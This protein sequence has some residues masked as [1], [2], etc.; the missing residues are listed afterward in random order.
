MAAHGTAVAGVAPLDA[1]PGA[2][3]ELAVRLPFAD[4]ELVADALGV[5]APGGVTLEPTIRRPDDRELAYEVTRDGALVR[6]FFYAPLAGHERRALR[7]RLAAL[8][9][10]SRLPRL[11]YRAVEDLDW[12]HAWK[13]QFKTLRIGRL[14]VRPSWE[15]AEPGDSEIAVTLDLGRAF[16]TGQHPTTRLCLAAIERTLAAGA[17][18][19]CVLDVGTGSGILA[20][21]A[22]RLGAARVDALDLDAEAV[23]VA[24]DNAR[25]NGLEDHIR[26]AEGSLGR[27]WPAGWDVPA[28]GYELVVVNISSAAV[29]ELMPAAA[30]ALRP[31]GRLIASGFMTER[32]TRLE[33]AAREAGLIS[34]GVEHD[35]EWSAL[36]ADRPG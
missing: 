26:I 19:G 31:G 7:R 15:P 6:A 3:V 34:V 13:E 8:P 30:E 35:G 11:R 14:V 1:A 10:G 21:A 24:R 29:Q 27:A 25:R 12:S 22:A 4:A 18:G 36:G 23:A 17:R 2:W 28:R 33:A 5:L 32:A 9:L 16:G 20:L